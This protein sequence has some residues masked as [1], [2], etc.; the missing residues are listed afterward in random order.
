MAVGQTCDGDRVSAETRFR[1][2]ALALGARSAGGCLD[3]VGVELE[4]VVGGCL[5]PLLRAGRG[6]ASPLEAAEATIELVLGE[7]RLDR[8][9][10]CV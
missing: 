5:E 8:G 4:Q 2:N 9:F 1:G 7:D 6:C 3:P 10:A